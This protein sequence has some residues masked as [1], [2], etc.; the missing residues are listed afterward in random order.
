[1]DLMISGR[2]FDVTD[3]LKAHVGDRIGRLEREYSKLINAQ[4]VMELVRNWNVA[5]VH[6]QGKNVHLDASS[7]TQDMYVSVD[8][9]V[10]KAE[11]Q[12]RRYLDKVQDHHLRGRGA[13]AEE[14]SAEE[15]IEEADLDEEL[16]EVYEEE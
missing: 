15:D 4:V 5:T 10:S 8:D 3:E 6:V 12:L 16:E 11:K 13:P 1:M 7:R 2:N 14:S 9:A